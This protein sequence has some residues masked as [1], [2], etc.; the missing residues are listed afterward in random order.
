MQAASFSR[1]SCGHVEVG[2]DLVDVVVLFERVDQAQQVFGLAALDLD[3]ALR[4][5]RHVGGL[6]LDPGLLQRLAHGAQVGRLADHAQLLA[7]LAH[8]LG[9]GVDRGDQVVLAVAVAVDDDHAAFLE[10]PGDRAGLAE[11]AVVLGEGVAHLGAGAVAV[12]GQR[13]DQDRRA[14]GP[15]AL[16]ED[17]LDRLGVGADAGAAVDRPLDVVLRHRGV[18]G[19]LD[20]RRQGRVAVGVAA[21]I[22]RRDG[23][24]PRQLGE[25]LAALGVGGAL[26]VLDRRPLRMSGHTWHSMNVEMVSD[27][28]PRRAGPGPGGEHHLRRRCCSPRCRSGPRSR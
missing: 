26:L 13:L 12:V 21:A 8:V 14:A 20:R 11:A 24:R 22:A 23:D 15:V 10:D 19:L 16:E 27:S 1:I 9:A 25:E 6:D 7:V 5:H 4:L 17:P 18:A 3:R 28:P 2:V